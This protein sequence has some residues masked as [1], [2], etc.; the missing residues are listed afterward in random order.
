LEPKFWTELCTQLGCPEL[1]PRQFE[2]PQDEVKARIAAIFRT[3]SAEAWFEQLRASD[4][5]VTPVRTVSE[6][7]AEMPPRNGS[8]PPALGEHTDEVLAPY[9]HL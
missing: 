4:C 2:D 5:C 6:V 9:Q 7:A 8:P 3:K 1:I